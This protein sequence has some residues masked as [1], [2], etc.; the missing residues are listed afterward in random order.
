MPE[1]ELHVAD[2]GAARVRDG[3]A[4]TAERRVDAVL[5][6]EALSSDHAA[7][8]GQ[9]LALERDVGDDQIDVAVQIDVGGRE[10][11]RRRT[12]WNADRGRKSRP[13]ETE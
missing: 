8:A 10:E 11:R 2:A 6:E 1:R 4:R 9:R 13:A 7:A 3:A 12:R 5:R